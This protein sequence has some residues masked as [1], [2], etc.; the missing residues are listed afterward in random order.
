MYITITTTYSI[1]E[2]KNESSLLTF[3]PLTLLL[4]IR[5][6]NTN[7]TSLNGKYLNMIV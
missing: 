3:L 7:K 4:I 1:C 5:L 2:C 6:L